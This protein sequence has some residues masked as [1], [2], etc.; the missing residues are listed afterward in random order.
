MTRYR[1]ACPIGTGL[2]IGGVKQSGWGRDS[3]RQ[4]LENY[5]EWKTVC[6]VV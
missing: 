1:H 3:G 6:A 2:A 5:L 4:A